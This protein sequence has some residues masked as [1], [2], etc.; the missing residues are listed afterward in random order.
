LNQP[1]ISEAQL[2]SAINR[3]YVNEFL[4]LLPEGLET[5]LGDSAARLSVGQAQRVA[6]ARA[7]LSPCR[8]LLLDEPTASLDAHSEKRVMSALN[9][10]SRSQTTLLVTHQLEDTR[11]YDEIWVM[12]KG[13][14]AERGTFTQLV[15]QGG[16]FA[17]LLSQRSKE[18]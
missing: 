11:D 9:E 15:A 8:L 4:P 2:Q 5:E 12:D 18:L 10:A 7:L 17:S 3:A 14:I 16:L 1:D 6:V 13:Q